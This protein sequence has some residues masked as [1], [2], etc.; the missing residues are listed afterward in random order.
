MACRRHSVLVLEPDHEIGSPIPTSGGSCSD[1]L[2]A[3]G[4]PAHL[5]HPISRIRFLSPN[6]AAQYDY[7]LPQLCVIDVRGVFQ[8]LAQRAAAA[9]AQIQLST[10]AISP[11]LESGAVTGVTTPADSLRC[12]L[13]VDATGYKSVLLKQAGLDPGFRRF[14]VGAE[15]DM[16]APHCDQ[17]EALL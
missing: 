10:A 4:I 14:G 8:H 13:L 15:Y 16:I 5:Y 2:S 7:A 11:I 1:E 3:L 17:N 12:R 9:G 6:H